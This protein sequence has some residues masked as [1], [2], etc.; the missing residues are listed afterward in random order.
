MSDSD[1]TR[2]IVA[3]FVA[4]PFVAVSIGSVSRWPGLFRAGRYCSGLLEIG[5]VPRR[6]VLFR[7]CFDLV[8]LF[9]LTSF[10]FRVPTTKALNRLTSLSTV[11]IGT[12]GG[13]GSGAG[14]GVKG[15]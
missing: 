12:G 3:P 7:R 1:S 6:S 11:L 13:P 4:V 9:S 8:Y 10:R 14:I 15:W 2:A 5:T